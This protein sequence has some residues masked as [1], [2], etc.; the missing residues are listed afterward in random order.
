MFLRCFNIKFE[1]YFSKLGLPNISLV[2]ILKAIFRAYWID[3]RLEQEVFAWHLELKLLFIIVVGFVRR[4]KI[5]FIFK[6]SSLAAKALL[7]DLVKRRYSDCPADSVSIMV[8]QAVRTFPSVH[9]FR[10]S[11]FF[12]SSHSYLFNHFL[13]LN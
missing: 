5:N 9:Y 2:I 12:H 7:F 10:L 4:R 1:L 11:L 13:N 3:K 8:N 6:V